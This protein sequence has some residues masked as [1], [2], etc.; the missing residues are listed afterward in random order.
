MIMQD[1]VAYKEHLD[2]RHFS[3]KWGE[4]RSA[5]ER[6]RFSTNICGKAMGFFI[7]LNFKQPLPLCSTSDKNRLPGVC[8]Y[9]ILISKSQGKNLSSSEKDLGF[10]GL[11]IYELFEINAG[12]LGEGKRTR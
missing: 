8:T 2:P 9:N 4:L 6:L 1:P 5:A 11:R 10:P 12:G 7:C 3:G